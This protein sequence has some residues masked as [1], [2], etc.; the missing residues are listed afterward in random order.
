MLW[1]DKKYYT[2]GEQWSYLPPEHRPGGTKALHTDWI[3]PFSLIPRAYTSFYFALANVRKGNPKTELWWHMNIPKPWY[4]QVTD[5][6]F[7][8]IDGRMR[9]KTYR[10]FDLWGWRFRFGARLSD[11]LEANPPTVY[12]SYIPIPILGFFLTCGAKRI[13]GL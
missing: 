5:I 13:K 10:C 11:D 3:F 8:E 12:V 1:F 2:P 7:K 4:P 6:L 9:L